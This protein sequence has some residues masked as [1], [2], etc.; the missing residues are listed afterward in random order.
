MVQ[1]H[2]VGH[3]PEVRTSTPRAGILWREF[4]HFQPDHSAQIVSQITQRAHDFA[5]PA[6]PPPEAALTAGI[7]PAP[8]LIK[9]AAALISHLKTPPILVNNS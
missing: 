8:T 5:C 7:S 3:L 2:D 9:M 6:G 4:S 1:A